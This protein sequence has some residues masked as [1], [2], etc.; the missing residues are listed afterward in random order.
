MTRL[1]KFPFHPLLLAVYPVLAL[2]AV[3]IKEVSSSV[4][5]R[6]LLISI[7]FGMLII[8]ILRLIFRD[9]LKA[10]LLTSLILLI[11]FSYGRIYDYL[12]T[13]R[14]ADLNLVRHR[15]L[16]LFFCILLVLISWWIL[17]HIRDYKPITAVFNT[18]TIVLAL[19]TGIQ[20]ISFQIKAASG[21]QAASN[22]NPGSNMTP[23]TQS[24]NKPDVYYIVL[25]SY[26]RS[27][28]LMAELDFDNSGFIQQLRDMGF[29]VANCSRANYNMTQSSMVSSLN[30]SYLPELYAEA[31]G[32]GIAAADIWVLIKSSAVRKSFQNLGYKFV[33]FETGYK[34][35]SVEDA[36][37]YLMRSQ[38]SFGIQFVTPFEQMLIDSTT[39]SIYSDYQRRNTLLKYFGSTH[40]LA[41][42]IGMEE[43]I[44]S[45]LPKIPEIDAPTFTY[46]HIN[47]THKPYVFSP[48]GYLDYPD[49]ISTVA[50]DNR[51]FP[52][53]YISSI[54]YVDAQMLA[55]IRE[56]LSRSDTPPIIIVQGDH[57]Y[58]VDTA[59]DWA[60]ISPILNAYYLPGMANDRLYP[61]ISP[62]N[63]FRLIFND[64]F[65]GAYELLPDKSYDSEE[66]TLPLPEVMPDC[67]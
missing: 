18:I 19:L 15:Y 24:D 32:Q 38:D 13:T 10:A 35:T 3:N 49:E 27:D 42:Y 26:T 47:V 59:S 11:F 14:L 21:Q 61:T 64:Y 50:E 8:F 48:T 36:D 60:N 45:Q 6:P 66:I 30:M 57:G 9:W 54:E 65:G 29:Y 39:L 41:N 62:V 31:A 2:Y 44:L 63:T 4:I 52:A 17:R 34:W 58:R 56:I 37:L 23:T 43:F 33:A 40:P 53:G 5:W 16:A 22:W 67:Q 51:H 55:I 25:D 46:A 7:T 20:I 1:L 28:V 12:R